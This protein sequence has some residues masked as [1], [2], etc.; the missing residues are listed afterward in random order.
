[1][2]G[3]LARLADVS[4]EANMSMEPAGV[5][6]IATALGG[7]Y[8]ARGDAVAIAEAL[9][10]AGFSITKS[11]TLG[12]DSACESRRKADIHDGICYCAN[13]GGRLT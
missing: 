10:S 5:E 3:A 1:M 2:V 13:C 12:H 11:A 8:T 9:K 6:V 4:E 7:T